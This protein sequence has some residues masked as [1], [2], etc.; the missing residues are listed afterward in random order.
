VDAVVTID[1]A[2]EVRVRYGELGGYCA[3][4]VEIG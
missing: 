4:R 3:W 2:V 1:D